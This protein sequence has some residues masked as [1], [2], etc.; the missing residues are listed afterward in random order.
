MER[1]PYQS[2]NSRDGE[3]FREVREGIALETGV[4]TSK[5]NAVT[6][7]S[8]SKVGMVV[9]VGITRSK[10]KEINARIASYLEIVT[11]GIS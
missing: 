4:M 11:E 8:R 10:V 7:V 3:R 9:G 1:K 5:I 2:R 6:S